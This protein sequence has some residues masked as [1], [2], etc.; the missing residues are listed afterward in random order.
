MTDTHFVLPS[1]ADADMSKDDQGALL[2]NQA[3]A[4]IVKAYLENYSSTW[5]SI[6]FPWSSADNANATRLGFADADALYQARNETLMTPTSL[7]ALID[8]V[9]TSLRN[10]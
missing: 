5:S 10:F 4:V 9:Q 7:A 3:T 1:V 8:S 2:V 6:Y